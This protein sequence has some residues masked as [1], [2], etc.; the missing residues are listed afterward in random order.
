MLLRVS[1]LPLFVAGAMS[2]SQYAS[3]GSMRIVILTLRYEVIMFPL[4]IVAFHLYSF[5][6]INSMPIRSVFLLVSLL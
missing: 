6:G 4:L 5:L 2:N 3:L 1:S